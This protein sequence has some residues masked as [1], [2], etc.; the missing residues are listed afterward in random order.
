MSDMNGKT[1][2]HQANGRGAGRGGII[3]PVENRWKPGQSGNP[4]GRPTAGACI[5]EWMNEM[6]EWPLARIEK[7]MNDPKSPA[8]KVVAARTWIHSMTQDKNSSGMP[9]AGPDTDRLLDRT[10]GKPKQDI[11]VTMDASIQHK[12]DVQAVMEKVLSDPEAFA[13]AEILNKRLT[14]EP[15]TPAGSN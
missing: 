7:A 8:A 2:A 9:V 6:R 3:P 15:T 13:A 14:H 1:P 5:V 12:Q 10:V 11:D 4:K